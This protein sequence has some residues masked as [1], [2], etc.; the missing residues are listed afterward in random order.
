MAMSA[1]CAIVTAML[2]MAAAPL[3]AQTP[4]PE[5]TRPQPHTGGLTP[6][7]DRGFAGTTVE[8]STLEQ[9]DS[10]LG[11]TIAKLDRDDRGFTLTLEVRNLT[12]GPSTRQV[13]GAWVIAP[14]GTV[15]GYQRLESSREIAAGDSRTHGADR[16]AQHHHRAAGRHHDRRRAGIGRRAGLAAG[17]GVAAEGGAQPGRAAEAGVRAQ[18]IRGSDISASVL[19]SVSV[20]DASQTSRS[21]RVAIFFGELGERDAARR[22]RGVDRL[23]VLDREV[24][25]RARDGRSPATAATASA[26]PRR[27]R[28]TP[29]SA[30]P[31]T[32]RARPAC[33]DRRRRRGRCR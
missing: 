16:A 28:R 7:R 21:G 3:C 17:P 19:P 15:R 25:H 4:R 30:A 18:T 9:P 26:G 10:P 32:G 20:N 22:Q 5:P 8:A 24:E 33:R 29:G 6:F 11:V 14:D 13:L 2:W 23:D 31:R 12:M 1:R 27:N